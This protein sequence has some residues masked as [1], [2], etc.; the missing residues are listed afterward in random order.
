MGVV[1]GMLDADHRADKCLVGSC[2]ATELLYNIAFPLS[3][4]HPFR[5]TA[6]EGFRV[7]RTAPDELV[8]RT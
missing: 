6:D 3:K 5:C 2:G 1:D 4:G 8:P 7:K